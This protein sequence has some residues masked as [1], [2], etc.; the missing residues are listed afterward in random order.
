MLLGDGDFED[1]R[2]ES[3]PRADLSLAG[4]CGSAGRD[5]NDLR[6]EIARR[7]PALP[8]RFVE[9]LRTR[10]VDLRPEP[11]NATRGLYPQDGAV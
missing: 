7:L 8:T 3:V 4:L 10:R 1:I 5:A 11:I 6:G 9:E 2:A